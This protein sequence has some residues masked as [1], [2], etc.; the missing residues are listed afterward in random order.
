M[1]VPNRTNEITLA[2]ERST[3]WGTAR[4]NATCPSCNCY[5]RSHDARAAARDRPKLLLAA[6]HAPPPHA[7]AAAHAQ[8]RTTIRESYD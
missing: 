1:E 7:T 3:S 6:S 5:P 2:D 4:M 8:L